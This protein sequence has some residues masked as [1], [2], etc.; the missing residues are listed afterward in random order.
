MLKIVLGGALILAGLTAAEALAQPVDK[1]VAANYAPLMIEGDEGHPGYAVEVLR[2]AARRAGRQVVI[3]FLP[4]QRTMFAVNNDPATLMP[5]LF[6]GKKR[7]DDFLWL[8]EIQRAKLRFATISGRI[9]DLDRARAASSIAVESGTTAD[10][11]LSQLGFDNLMRVST[12]EASANMLA[13]GRVEAWFQTKGIV[14]QEWRRSAFS[15]PL[16]TGDII[17]EVPIFMVASPTFPPE[18]AGLYRNAVEAMRSEGLLDEI[19]QR[20]SLD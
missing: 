9:D 19:W 3:T 7:N 17:H 2:E 11:F 15:A 6:Y 8:V 14:L 18:V 16:G 10:V 12:P 4:F 5:A 13:A 20:Y 1:V